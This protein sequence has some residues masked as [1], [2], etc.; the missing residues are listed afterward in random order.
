MYGIKSLGIVPQSEK[1]SN[2]SLTTKIPMTSAG[3]DTGLTCCVAWLRALIVA[4]CY[5]ISHFNHAS[6]VPIILLFKCRY[7][8]LANGIG[9]DEAWLTKRT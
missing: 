4:V 7:S 9:C 5:A 3:H 2:L 1:Q 6:D 8:F